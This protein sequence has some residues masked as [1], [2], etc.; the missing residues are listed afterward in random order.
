MR[1][2]RVVN[3]VTPTSGGIRTALDALGAGYLA[4]GHDPV[5]VRPGI[6]IAGSY[7][8][9]GWTWTVPGTLVPGSGGYRLILRRAPLLRVLERLAPDRV[10]VSDKFTLTYVGAWARRAGVPALLFS[11]ERLDALL[12]LRTGL[13]A[14]GLVDAWNRRLVA[15]FDRIVTTTRWA[16][17]EFERV[18]APDLF[19]V[20]LGVDLAA[21]H[22]GAVERR[23]RGSARVLLVAATRL[24]PEKRP[25]LAVAA[26]AELRRRGVDARLVVAGDG[27]LRGRLTR[28]ARGLP[29]VFTG[30]VDS[31]ARL[32]GLLAAADVMLAPGPVETFGLAALEALACGTPLVTPDEGALP[33]L[34]A[35]GAGRAV[36][37]TPEAFAGAVPELLSHSARA[38][39]RARA[40][41]FPWAASVAGMLRAHGVKPG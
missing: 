14:S 21:F 19:R 30:H 25:G 3:F 24:S 12:R 16:T 9:A 27:P 36:P 6:E 22:P 32:A 26:L 2:I 23:W 34:L 39:A 38:A 7:G 29:V 5:L 35:A 31:R 20:P 17:A 8:P 10:E 37:S 18:A 33:E 40:E 1:I 4:A 28:A 11:H 15:R 13:P 41:C